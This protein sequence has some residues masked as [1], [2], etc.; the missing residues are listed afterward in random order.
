MTRQT[1]T[2]ELEPDD[3]GRDLSCRPANGD[4]AYDMLVARNHEL[5]RDKARLLDENER[6]RQQADTLH[7]V[8]HMLDLPAGCDVT[9]ETIPALQRLILYEH[10]SY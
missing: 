10:R 8:A 2:C 4:N 3:P 1:S 7:R 9:T 6:L 5:E